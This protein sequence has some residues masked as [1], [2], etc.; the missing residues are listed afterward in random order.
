MRDD[1][2]EML[3]SSLRRLL[4]ETDEAKVD[5]AL[6]QFGWHDLLAD[7]PDE[8]VPAL[9]EGQGEGV[10]ATPML[11]AVMTSVLLDDPSTGDGDWAVALP[12]GGRGGSPQS[13]LDAG[14]TLRVEG[15]CLGPLSD[16]SRILVAAQR[17]DERVIACV[18]GC[19]IDAVPV[20]G[21]DPALNLLR[22]TAVLAPSEVDISE[23][24]R[25]DAA[26]AAGRRALAHEL[27]GISRAALRLA[28][29]HAGER[30]QFGKPIGSYQAVKHRLAE[31]QVAVSAAELAATEA[32]TVGDPASA[33]LAKI[34][35]GRSARTVGTHAQQV[36]GGMGFTWEHPFHH[37]LRRALVDDV[38][39]GSAGELTA[40]LGRRLV[41]E[42]AL[43]RLAVL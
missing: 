40:E 6:R 26:V 7:E 30:R 23:G 19:S 28:V 41:T 21:M 34:S 14:G 31:A 10:H 5:E 33:V 18:D 36:L 29:A 11:N 17:G 8:A 35:A 12:P 22:V 43:P 39:L 2:R 37:L 15:Y 20:A 42:R 27:I 9:F 13:V 24:R 38:L 25:W 1:E 32:W 4:E 3:R 16:E